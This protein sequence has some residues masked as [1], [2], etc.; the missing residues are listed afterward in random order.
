MGPKSLC[1]IYNE[2]KTIRFRFRNVITLQDYIAAE[3]L[4]WGSDGPEWVY[5]YCLKRSG[6]HSLNGKF[7]NYALLSSREE[8]NKLG[9]MKESDMLSWLG[10]L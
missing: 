9:A 5:V 8:M 1:Q 10:V 3:V 2:Q 6:S 7:P 4:T